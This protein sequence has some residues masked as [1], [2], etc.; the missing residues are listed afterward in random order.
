V[1]DPLNKPTDIDFTVSNID[2]A[3]GTASVSLAVTGGGSISSYEILAPITVTNTTGVFPNLGLGS[4][5]FRV[6]DVNGCSYTESFAIT[7]ISSIGVTSQLIK[8]V[9]CVGASNGEGRFIVDGYS[10][11]YSYQ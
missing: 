3:S 4:Y 6:T 11:T 9:G 7:D 2:C 1:F 8:N 5:T 10:S